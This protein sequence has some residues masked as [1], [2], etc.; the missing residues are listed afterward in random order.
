MGNQ[1]S[2]PGVETRLNDRIFS[3]LLENAHDAIF[4]LDEKGTVL[5]GN[6]QAEKILGLSK[7]EMAGRPYH[8]FV[9]PD[10]LEY[11]VSKVEGVIDGKPDAHSEVRLRRSGGGIAFVE[12]SGTM[13]DLG[14]EKVMLSIGRDITDQKKAEEERSR[15]AAIVESSDDA[16][17]AM[18]LE[19][20]INVWNT[21]AENL[22]GYGAQEI[23]GRHIFVLVPAER[24]AEMLRML[25]SCKQGRP[26]SQ[27]E[28]VR[29]NRLQEKIPISVNWFP[30]KD[31]NARIV[32]VSAIVRD[33]TEQK[34]EEFFRTR[35]EKRT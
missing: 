26:L 35:E 28:T 20:I 7:M 6:K 24:H 10:D 18:D 11:A 4:V 2:H 21:S 13:V 23:L 22:F 16:I 17:Y 5:H 19:G 29:K 1:L 14:E 25:E 30:I 9:V 31:K 3:A 27:F 15:L 33:L 8:D 34:R 32:G 12:F